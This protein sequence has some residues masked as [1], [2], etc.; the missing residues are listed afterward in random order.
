LKPLYVLPDN[1]NDGFIDEDC[2]RE[3]EFTIPQFA[4]GIEFFLH[5]KTLT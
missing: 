2:I 1:D 5:F 4:R 3:E